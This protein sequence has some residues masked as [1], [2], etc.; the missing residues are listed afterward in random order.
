MFLLSYHYDSNNLI[1]HKFMIV[2]EGQHPQFHLCWCQ[3]SMKIYRIN[4]FLHELLLTIVEPS[5]DLRLVLGKSES[6]YN[7]FPIRSIIF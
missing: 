5:S 6:Q 2:S 4:F 1:R 7:I 3:V